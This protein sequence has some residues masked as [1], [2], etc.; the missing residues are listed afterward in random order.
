M[1]LALLTNPIPA[2]LLTPMNLYDVMVFSGDQW[3]PH[4]KRGTL[5]GLAAGRDAAAV[6]VSH[7]FADCQTDARACRLILAVQSLKNGENPV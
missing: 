1:W 4:R 2:V 7:F 3:Q 5:I 6:R